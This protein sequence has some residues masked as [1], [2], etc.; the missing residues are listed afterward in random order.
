MYRVLRYA[1]THTPHTP[2]THTYTHSHTQ[3]G[4]VAPTL[5]QSQ[6]TSAPSQ[7]SAA[8]QPPQLPGQ[9]GPQP[10]PP[11]PQLPEEGILEEQISDPDKRKLIQQWLVILLHA[12]ECQQ[13][14]R[15]HQEGG[16][17]DFRPCALPHC[18]TY[19][20]ILSHMTESQAGRECSCKQYFKFVTS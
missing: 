13:R 15:E 9:M 20:D 1:H 16:A 7:H 6:Q 14:E 4:S 5:P 2:H 11:M 18:R 19:K 12:E 3:P 10:G 8:Q 17:V